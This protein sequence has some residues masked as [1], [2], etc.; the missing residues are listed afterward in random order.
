[1]IRPQKV[2]AEAGKCLLLAPPASLT[3]G[4]AAPLYDKAVKA[5]SADIDLDQIV[6]WWAMP[7]EQLPL[8]EV[9]KV[10]DQHRESLKGAAQA[11]RCRECKWPRLTIGEAAAD[12]AEY[13]R[14]GCVVRL[15]TRYEIARGNYEAAI[16]AMQT[17]FGMGRYLTQ[18]PTLVQFIAG[19]SIVSMMGGEVEAF[20]QADGAPSLHSALVALPA[21]LADVEKAIENDK[22]TAS[23]EWSGMLAGEQ[24]EQIFESAAMRASYNGVRLLA[25]RLD[26]DL[27]ALQCIEALRSYAASHGGQLPQT[28]AEITEVAV[29]KDPTNGE[30]F[31]Y[32]RTGAT[33][34]LEST[35]PA[36]GEKKDGLRYEISVRN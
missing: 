10:L 11:A 36:G 27:A 25:K 33:A 5:L 23:S 22:K 3:D 30:A 1:M 2:S 4:D 18:A 9:K 31:R 15:W 12:A 26:R 8:Q 14:F 28:L 6:E 34:V 13:K 17:G 35:V 32:T 24:I 21:P 16:H 7:L 19:V 29:P 20:A